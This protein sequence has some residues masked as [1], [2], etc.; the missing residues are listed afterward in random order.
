MR[1]ENFN[2]LLDIYIDFY[3]NLGASSLD[4]VYCMCMCVVHQSLDYVKYV[5]SWERQKN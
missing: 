2:L 5:C 4:L 3:L 1:N